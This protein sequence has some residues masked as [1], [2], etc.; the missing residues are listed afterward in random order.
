MHRVALRCLFH[1]RV[2]LAAALVGV[3]V[4]TVLMLI[5]V[6][7]YHGFGAAASAPIRHIGGDV[8][9]M[10]RDN[11]QL[12]HSPVLFAGADASLRAHPCV[13]SVRAALFEFT[14]FRHADGT[15]DSLELVGVDL[16]G[17]PVPWSMARGLP[18]DL[19]APGRITV[20]VNDAAM[21]GAR[22]P[23]G[24]PLEIAGRTAHVGALTRGL[25]GNFGI[26]PIAFASARTARELAGLGPREASY[27]VAELEDPRCA[28][29]VIAAVERDPSLRAMGAE[30]FAERVERELLDTSGIGVALAF[31][32][33]LG[34][35]VAA[36]IVAQTLLA[37]LRQ[38]RRELAM[39]KAL[40]ARPAEL[41]S[42]VAWQTALLASVGVAAGVG[43]AYLLR[44]GLSGLSVPVVLPAGAVALGAL[45]V[46][47][48]CAAASL[49]SVR[50]ILRIEA[51]EV[52]R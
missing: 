20:D 33:L 24:A 26:H 8:W 34:F 51:D 23:I 36:T 29:S 37:S 1:D 46:L 47:G 43:L 13:R 15:L 5:Q 2:R 45:T 11:R 44:E 3:A 35:A 14:T 50:A 4:A 27:W 18:S 7:I 21:L 22:D 12:D 48:L 30:A 31:I 17:A 6:G 41:V 49:G 32:A 42:F 19:N 25:R 16:A 52:L 28:P 39:L 40:G 10:S 38:H 9:V